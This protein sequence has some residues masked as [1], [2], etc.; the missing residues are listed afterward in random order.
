MLNS[1]N[2]NLNTTE[3]LAHDLDSTSNNVLLNR[4]NAEVG[5]NVPNLPESSEKNKRLDDRPYKCE[6]EGCSSAFKTKDTL[7]RHITTHSNDRPYKCKVEGCSS[8]FKTKVNLNRHIKIHNNNR[9]YKCEVEGCD[10]TTK[11]KNTLKKHIASHSSND[12]LHKCTV[13]GCDYITKRKYNL[14]IHMLKHSDDRPYKCTVEGCDYTAKIKIAL[15]QHMVRHS[16]DRPY[17]CKV[18][19]CSSAFKI[20]SDLKRHMLRHIKVGVYKCNFEN[21]NYSTSDQST[22]ARHITLDHNTYND[23]G[24][25]Y[26]PL[27][28]YSSGFNEMQVMFPTSNSVNEGFPTTVLNSEQNTYWSNYDNYNDNSQVGL[29]I[30]QTLGSPSTST[31][32]SVLQMPF[33]VGNLNVLSHDNV[34][35]NTTT[36]SEDY[37]YITSDQSTLA[38]H[39]TSGHNTSNDNGIQ[40][41]PLNMYSADSNITPVMFPISNFEVLPSAKIWG[42]QLNDS[43]V[44]NDLQE[45][46]KEHDEEFP[47]PMLYSEQNNYY[48]NYNNYNDNIQVNTNTSQTLASFSTEI[49]DSRLND[50]L[51]IDSLYDHSVQPLSEHNLST[52]DVCANPITTE[53][54]PTQTSD[55][56]NNCADTV[57]LFSFQKQ[58]TNAI[59]LSIFDDHEQQSSL[60]FNN[61]GDVL[62]D[63]TQLQELNSTLSKS[64]NK[65]RLHECK[66][67]KFKAKYLRDLVFHIALK[68]NMTRPKSIKKYYKRKYKNIRFDLTG[69][70]VVSRLKPSSDKTQGL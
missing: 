6:V 13:E 60:E 21:C 23:D 27:N 4:S 19:N 28:M 53:L 30:S 8:A 65:R 10:Y 40:Y 34:N 31:Y 5:D 55:N 58:N 68:H 3:L 62:R 43:N 7:N 44:S 50:L 38:R 59:D 70:V 42:F 11:I 18:G 37:N 32:N 46:S 1:Y 47:V 51:N 16:N 52:M 2:A 17:K 22:L 36:S 25:Q 15:N 69:Q 35:P 12:K 66:K 57:D 20:L 29:D 49:W 64:S 54:L 26:P 48:S 56:I 14:K 67:C 45:I 24:I 33:N 9:S 41:S 63:T 61:Q 39:I